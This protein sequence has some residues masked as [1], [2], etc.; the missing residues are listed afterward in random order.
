MVGYGL[1]GEVFHCP[2]IAATPGLE[3]SAIVT[4][5]RDRASRAKLRYPKAHVAATFEELLL[6]PGAIDL[7]VVA[8]P[9]HLHYPQAR[10]GLERGWHV[11]VDKPLGLTAAEG[12]ALDAAARA[13]GLL[14]GVFH[15]RRW[16]GDFLL[17]RT[18]L[19][20]GRLGPIRVL[21]SR[22][23]RWRPELSPGSWRE[24]LPPERGGGLLLD[25]GSHLIDQAL[26]PLGEPE[27][28]YCQLGRRRG[29]AAEDDCLV[30]I[31][32]AGGALG[33]LHI[34][35]VAASLGPRFRLLGMGGAVETWGLDPQEEQLR[36][37]QVPKDPGFGLGGA[38][39]R[40]EWLQDGR[41]S[42]DG[43]QLPLPE[44]RYLDF[45][46]QMERAIQGRGP[47]PVAASA[48]IRSLQVIEA[49]RRS[50]QLG[51]VVTLEGLA[52]P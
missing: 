32:F 24:G 43:D 1:A 8:T 39:Y 50:A 48:G 7:L 6:E 5:D 49:A 37:G 15:N 2:L 17:L 34:S 51:E 46:L 3:I 9:N 31:H 42:G 28:A 21:E 47:V 19:G 13:A 22:F 10:A 4:G 33:L 12:I 23:E 30:A 52:S 29:G 27:S 44:G 14:L 20:S 35:A 45:Y 36:L 41:S 38:R 16:D 11:V 25:L 18:I 26:V 40:A